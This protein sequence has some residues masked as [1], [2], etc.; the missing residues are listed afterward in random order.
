MNL[1]AFLLLAILLTSLVMVAWQILLDLP[2]E[3]GGL[4]RRYR[5]KYK[6]EIE[7]GRMP[8][9]LR[10]HVIDVL[11]RHR[12]GWFL[13]VPGALVLAFF[14]WVSPW[15]L[16]FVGIDKTGQS[17]GTVVVAVLALPVLAFVWFVR[18]YERD[19]ELTREE[20]N[21]WSEEFDRLMRA[22]ADPDPKRQVLRRASIRQLQ[23]YL[24]GAK[25]R[26]NQRSNS[27]AVFEL[28]SSIVDE[29]WRKAEETLQASDKNSRREALD[30]L[31]KEPILLTVG[32]VL[33]A[34]FAR[35]HE[36]S[37]VRV[38]QNSLANLHFD[39]LDLRGINLAGLLVTYSTFRFADLS[40][41]NLSWANLYGAN[42]YGAYLH[43]ANLHG[44]NLNRVHLPE[45]YLNGANLSGAN[46]SGASLY[47]DDLSWARLSEANLWGAIL[48]GTR[49]YKKATLERFPNIKHDE[50]TK[51]DEPE[52]K[53]KNKGRATRNARRR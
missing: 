15:V 51:W 37:P 13:L 12:F 25:W 50:N 28:F 46:L 31:R 52:S 4:N 35:E 7:S 27:T 16:D 38:S 49:L 33:C 36:I 32:A 24:S 8:D 9:S 1:L 30:K 40:E 20:A 11:Y 18:A 53:P 23:D 3:R 6:P 34:V 42:L 17:A 45:A 21:L 2:A 22:A 29:H 39:L 47:W 48:K 5:D 14:L 43:G 26:T 10:Q 44:A 19:R 41:A